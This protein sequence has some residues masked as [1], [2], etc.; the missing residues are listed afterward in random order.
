VRV[1]GIAPRAGDL[2][3]IDQDRVDAAKVRAAASFPDDPLVAGFDVSGGGQAWNIVWFR[4]GLDA[5]SIPPIAIPGEHSQ[6]R[7][8]ILAKLSEILG[9][10]RPGHRVSMMFVDSAYGAPY[11][12]RLRTRFDNIQEVNFGAPSPDRHQANMRAYMWERMKAWLER[13]AIPV[14]DVVLETDLTAPGS[15]LNRS[16]QLVIESK[17][18]MAKRGVASPDR[19]DALA[20]TF[21]AHV[22]PVSAEERESGRYGGGAGS[23]MG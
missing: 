16:D 18:S 23:W 15:H 22:P 11:V 13:G 6:E 9:D 8:A 3:F 14:D 7:S 20:L 1:K 19:G 12:E 4:R 17:E 5:R 2:Q 21:A 10:K